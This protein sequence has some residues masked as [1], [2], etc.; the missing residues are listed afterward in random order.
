MKKISILFIALLLA[1][2]VSADDISNFNAL[3]GRLLPNYSSSFAAK[4][5]P[6][7]GYDYFT[8][9]S[10]NGKIEIGGNDANS[11]A[12]GL[13]Y[14]LKYY[15][16][17]TV[18]WYAGDRIDMPKSLPA[19]KE[20]VTI[21]A[22]CKNRFFLNYCTF[23]YTM[24]WWK[25]KDWEHFIDWMA[26]NG[27]NL[28]LAITGQESIWHKVWTGLGL[29]DKEV[30]HYFTGPAHLP[31]HRMLNIDYWQG[32]MPMS[33]LNDQE[34]LQK[35]IVAR[36]REFNMKPVLPA[37][38]GHVPQEL[39][40]IFPNAK[41]NKLGAWA[42]FSDQYACSF[43]DP[44]DTLFPK[45]QQLFMKQ[46]QA[47]YGSD[48]I[49]GID[50]FNEVEPPSFEP[51]YLHRVANRVYSTLKNVDKS[52]TWLQMTWLFYFQSKI[53][54][55]ERIKPYITA[56]P[57]N[58]SIL[59]D[60]FCE[61]QEVWK[62]TDKYFGVPYIWCYLGNF[63]GNT[64]LAGDINLV[65]NR[66]ENTVKNGGKNFAG[67][68]S[69]L[70]GLNCNPF[71]YEYVLEKAWEIDTHKNIAA[72]TDHIADEHAG[73]V[74][75]NARAAWQLLV[76]K[77][78]PQTRSDDHG[79]MIVVRP[80]FANYAKDYVSYRPRYK[81]ADLVNALSLMMKVNSNTQAYTTD[82]VNLT[83]QMLENYFD[84]V[85]GEYQQA[86]NSND[87]VAMKSHEATMTGIINDLE[88]LVA[89]QQ[90]YSMGKWIADARDK[91]LNNDEKL[92]Y[93]RNARCLLTSWGEKHHP[94][95][96]Y[97]ARS[98][99]GV[100]STYYGVRW[101][102]FFD[103]VDRAVLKGE[104]FDDK[105]YQDYVTDVT[106]FEERWW[107]D[108]IGNFSATPQGD[109]IAVAHELYS[110]YLPLINGGK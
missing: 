7:K 27:V 22:R 38:A 74:D 63:G 11:M 91:G 13:N 44:D 14:Y 79:S 95:N 68:G 49:Y 100:L 108:G 46:Q 97:A 50:L 19:L 107:H 18:S 64:T 56:Y 109:G 35:Q 69:T 58:K 92:Y 6:A 2:A 26:L 25:W 102:M 96:D 12:V 43:L 36:E 70:E 4:K 45:I 61:E 82:I 21:K 33:W 105:H 34:E 42:G 48:H 98:W 85:L 103:A 106:N 67:I 51:N 87:F 32:D 5:L 30:R 23:G 20:P 99:S 65:N 3:V 66:I 39:K 90:G 104:K 71:M 17:T 28:P 47:I 60:Y 80:I 78:Y 62:R 81:N 37:F 31:W 40:R 54:T 83:R 10:A 52:S 84:T 93:E 55:N 16:N 41:I 57:T 24:P 29:S 86:Y 59:L 94:L 9:S 77:V 8:V 75:N 89:T 101:S 72:W 88:R 73:K 53:W 15:C 1:T 110:K 76:S